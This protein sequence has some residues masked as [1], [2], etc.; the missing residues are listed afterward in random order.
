MSQHDTA[1]TDV[2][3]ATDL[4]EDL[5]MLEQEL[6][7][8]VG[9]PLVEPVESPVETAGEPAVEPAGAET[10]P[11]EEPTEQGGH[12]LPGTD[13][14]Q[15]GS[16]SAAPA[17]DGAPDAGGAQVEPQAGVSVEPTDP[18]AAEQAPPAGAPVEPSEA[19]GSEAAGSEAAEGGSDVEAATRAKHEL[20]VA[21]EAIAA[22]P[23]VDDADKAPDDRALTERLRELESA[24]GS[25]ASAGPAEGELR[26]RYQAA[27]ATYAAARAR[28]AESRAV[29]RA[30][31]AET[32]RAL[33]VEAFAL[34]QLA[35]G[36]TLAELAG[37]RLD[38]DVAQAAPQRGAS[39]SA[40]SVAPQQAE[41]PYEPVQ[42]DVAE[43]AAETAAGPP[44]AAAA[45]A[46]EAGVGDVALVADA[47]DPG[48]DEPQESLEP[49]D[50]GGSGDAV[51]AGMEASAE[52][53]GE[54]TSAAS[55]LEQVDT[56]GEE[57]GTADPATLSP[58][59]SAEGRAPAEAPVVRPV[60]AAAV[61]IAALA[62]RSQELQR[63]WTTAGFAGREV[64][65]EL[66][67]LFRRYLQV[68][69]DVQRREGAGKA[70]ARRAL[71]GAARAL[72]EQAA[73][74]DG[75]A[76]QRLVREAKAL[77][78]RWKEE[79]AA[80]RGVE[81]STWRQLSGALREVFAARERL[82]DSAKGEREAIVAAAAGLTS[83]RDPL[84]AVRDLG[85]L[86][87]RWRESGPVSTPVYEE[88]KGRLDS[89]AT[90]VRERADAERSRRDAEQSKQESERA[91]NASSILR[92]AERGRRAGGP[93]RERPS[94]PASA[95]AQGALAAALADAFGRAERVATEVRRLEAQAGE[96]RDRLTKAEAGA[97]QV[98]AMERVGTGQGF[99]VR[100]AVD[101]G[102]ANP[103][104]VRAELEQ[105]ETALVRRRAELDELTSSARGLG[106]AG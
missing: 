103:V 21:A 13:V 38:D 90:S 92:E 59:G 76:L 96:L 83:A 87:R 22:T 24:W 35:Q 41:A 67:P 39:P 79:E 40:S 74:A 19:A 25:L 49:Q 91:K 105:A 46:S 15:L 20:V 71:V 101:P 2:T 43:R 29:D 4:P 60:P 86:L 65:S 104:R 16:E 47:Q 56:D 77:Q 9:Q 11:L 72:A 8:A 62:R 78:Q 75:A 94:R 52:T 34:S 36:T 7:A 93:A 61:D 37:K 18:P 102:A 68:V 1:M 26:R 57:E 97:L 55:A 69:F 58:T 23:D 44:E 53:D 100:A 28:R 82:A 85:P 95:G 88:L 80:P 17:L 32:K 3:S 81:T 12:M 33:L 6:P 73:T 54:Q 99:T 42:D 84:R 27:R 98:D 31:A 106:L 64:E 45:P 5:P 30:R 70:S 63:E 89:A 48:R 51:E 50:G 66:Y 10:P 14:E